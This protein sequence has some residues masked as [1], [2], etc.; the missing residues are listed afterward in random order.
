MND[1]HRGMTRRRS[2]E[3]HGA[4]MVCITRGDKLI[5]ENKVRD[6]KRYHT[7][8]GPVSVMVATPEVTWAGVYETDV[9]A[10]Q[11]RL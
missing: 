4:R 8:E 5:S 11:R 1:E 2:A 3:P 7:S 9:R 10:M 6:K